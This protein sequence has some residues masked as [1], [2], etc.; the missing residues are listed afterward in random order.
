MVDPSPLA[1][2]PYLACLLHI[3][4]QC[5]TCKIDE[6]MKLF[7][8]KW[9]KNTQ[10]LFVEHGRVQECIAS[11]EAVSL[12]FFQKLTFYRTRIIADV[13]M[14][15]DIREKALLTK[16]SASWTPETSRL[17]DLVA[18]Y[19]L[20]SNAQLCFSNWNS[21]RRQMMHALFSYIA[22]LER[23]EEDQGSSPQLRIEIM[24][25]KN[26][27]W[28]STEWFI[29]EAKQMARNYRDENFCYIDA[30]HG[31]RA[32]VKEYRNAAIDGARGLLND[33]EEDVDKTLLC[34]IL[35]TLNG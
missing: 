7:E 25:A 18:G 21:L 2:S 33:I 13:C 35:N 20:S 24:C 32:A 10:E 12:E 19:W 9:A 14:L 15:D 28:E 22:E 16:A 30:N 23:V 29:K 11:G 6:N 1:F 8:S 17:R 31:S 3:V 27:I 5:G 26:A 34:T 4:T